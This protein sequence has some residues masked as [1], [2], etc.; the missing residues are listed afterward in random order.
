M[1]E[2]AEADAKKLSKMLGPLV[3]AYKEWI[4]GEEKKLDDPSEGLDQ[5]GAAPR[6]AIDNCRLNAGA[7]RARITTFACRTAK[8]FEAFQFMNR[9]M[10]LQRTKSIFAENVRR[11]AQVLYEDIDIP[12]NRSWRTFQI[13]FIANTTGDTPCSRPDPSCRRR[14]PSRLPSYHGLWKEEQIGNGV[15]AFASF[16][17]VKLGD[18]RQVEQNEGDL[19]CPPASVLGNVEILS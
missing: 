10:W 6:V 17:M 3:T 16:G 4:D 11:G 12:K 8:R 13:A 14:G 9:A 5:F 7:D 2:L 19:E 15:C 18:A 1:K